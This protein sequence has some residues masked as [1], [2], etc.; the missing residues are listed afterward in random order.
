VIII[1]Y[2]KARQGQRIFT[3]IKIRA[4]NEKTGYKKV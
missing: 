1:D 2:L 4:G 3:R